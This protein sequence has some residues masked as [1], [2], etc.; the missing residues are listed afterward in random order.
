MLAASLI[1]PEKVLVTVVVFKYEQCVQKPVKTQLASTWG[2]I[3]RLRGGPRRSCGVQNI[4]VSPRTSYNH[5]RAM[6]IFFLA[7]GFAVL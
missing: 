1:K 5:H 3:A 2:S 6:F 7:R 4:D